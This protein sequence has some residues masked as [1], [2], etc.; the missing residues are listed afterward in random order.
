M[1]HLSAGKG[2][3][4]II[5]FCLSAPLTLRAQNST[6][7]PE[8]KTAPAPSKTGVYTGREVF[9]PETPE[10]KEPEPPAASFSNDF[11]RFTRRHMGFTVRVSDTYSPNAIVSSGE[12]RTLTIKTIEPQMF[13]NV[14]KKRLDFRLTYGVSGNQYSSILGNRNSLSQNGSALFSYNL[15]GRKTTLQFSNSLTS[16]YYDEGSLLAAS[17]TTP[18]RLNFVPQVY[19]D[20]RRETRDLASTTFGYSVTKKASISASLNYDVSGYSGSGLERRGVLSGGLGAKYRIT[21]WL[22]FNTQYSRY[23]NNAGQRLSGS[24][25]QSLQ[26]GGFSF[27][28]ARNLV[29]TVS[30]GVDTT[31]VNSTRWIV[32]SGQ[33]SISKTSRNTSVEL[34]YHR[35]VFTLFPSTEVF[36][37]DTANLYA[38]RKLSRRINIQ[39]NSSVVRGA[40]LGQSFVAR[41]AYGGAGLDIALLNNLVFTTNYN[42]VSQKLTQTSLTGESLHR[43]SVGAGFQYFYPSVVRR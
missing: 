2:L 10:Q 11:L 8:Q 23:L 28:P 6:T 36:S 3:S 40:A 25:Y 12:K 31:S 33:A 24:N 30:G 5:L 37:G 17:L 20:R 4:L 32:G 42:L 38:V 7:S 27:K 41:T 14:Q 43:Y 1:T 18:Y 19:L 35:G 34:T 39:M 21:K 9:V 13:L 26:V 22:D 16:I 29:I 15:S